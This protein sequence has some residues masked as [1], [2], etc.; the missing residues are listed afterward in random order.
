MPTTME[1]KV[2]S[3]VAIV[4][5]TLAEQIKNFTTTL[6]TVV[7]ELVSYFD[8]IGHIHLD[9]ARTLCQELLKAMI[10]SD[11]YMEKV[12]TFA[13]HARHKR[14]Q[15]KVVEALEQETPQFEPMMEYISQLQHSLSQAEDSR[16][17]FQEF[18]S[19]LRSLEKVLAVCKINKE[20]LKS[21]KATGAMLGAIVGSAIGLAVLEAIP[22]YSVLAQVASM[23]ILTSSGAVVGTG[24]GI[25]TVGATREHV[26]LVN[27]IPALT[28]LVSSIERNTASIRSTICEVRLKLDS[29]SEVTIDKI[30]SDSYESLMACL[31]SLFEKLNE[32]GNTCSVSRQELE[33]KKVLLENTVDKL[34]E[35]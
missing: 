2:L 24:I 25:V 15:N 18:S 29:I 4:L 1:V 19:N 35:S 21:A 20:E 11:A 10:Y 26:K 34:L 28:T 3:D 23:I 6:A 14:R 12:D 22:N 9:E 5:P 33:K 31:N 16:T 27:A 7:D 30:D 8:K 32:F 17:I 13:W